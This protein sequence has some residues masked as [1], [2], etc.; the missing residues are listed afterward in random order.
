[1]ARLIGIYEQT[2]S[3]DARQV[4]CRFRW[5]ADASS[6]ST[7]S[8]GDDSYPIQGSRDAA[9]SGAVPKGRAG[10]ADPRKAPWLSASLNN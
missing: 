4:I 9:T 10:N 8:G 2:T 6:E 3:A 7:E 5:K 1:M